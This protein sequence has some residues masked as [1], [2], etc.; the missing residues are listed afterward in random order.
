MDEHVSATGIRRDETKTLVCVEELYL[1]RRHVAL[2]YCYVVGQ[3]IF[4]G[5]LNQ[6]SSAAAL[7]KSPQTTGK[8]IVVADR[9]SAFERHVKS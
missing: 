4:R 7:R 5:M 9:E 8:L 6:A 2:A 1:T 3:P